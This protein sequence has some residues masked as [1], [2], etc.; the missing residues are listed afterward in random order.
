MLEKAWEKKRVD[1]NLKAFAGNVLQAMN[2]NKEFRR[3]IM[4]GLRKKKNKGG[5]KKGE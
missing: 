2:N 4:Q 1:P 5:R 3:M